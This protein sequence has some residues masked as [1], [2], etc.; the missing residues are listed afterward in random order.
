MA[1]DLKS[2]FILAPSLGGSETPGKTIAN[3]YINWNPRDLGAL[4]IKET[5][6]EEKEKMRSALKQLKY[7]GRG[8]LLATSL[9]NLA[10]KMAEIGAPAINIPYYQDSEVSQGQDEIIASLRGLYDNDD[11]RKEDYARQGI[12]PRKEAPYTEGDF[13]SPSESPFGEVLVKPRG[14][15]PDPD[16]LEYPDPPTGGDMGGI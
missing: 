6:P 4:F 14:D 10:L 11:A 1:K 15:G 12:R 9:R 5:D 16:G 8:V 13:L 3:K 2:N 7:P